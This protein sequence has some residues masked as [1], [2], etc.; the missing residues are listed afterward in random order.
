M[1]LFRRGTLNCERSS[2][3][4]F[5]FFFGLGNP[6][7]QVQDPGSPLTHQ[8]FGTYGRTISDENETDPDAEIYRLRLAPT[9]GIIWPSRLF[10]PLRRYVSAPARISAVATCDILINIELT[11]LSGLVYCELSHP[12]ELL[13]I[14]E[15]YRRRKLFGEAATFIRAGT[16]MRMEAWFLTS[17]LKHVEMAMSN[18]F[19]FLLVHLRAAS[20]IMST[21]GPLTS[22]PPPSP[23]PAHLPL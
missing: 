18:P 22:Q 20:H 1:M 17:S 6:S 21:R 10:L 11:T 12:G 4:P 19:S 9:M 14:E 3:P 13:V 8:C 16:G 15:D 5:L 2:F 23:P 7:R